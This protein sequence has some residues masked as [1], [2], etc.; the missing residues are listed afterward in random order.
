MARQQLGSFNV[1]SE[2]EDYIITV[3]GEDGTSTEFTANYEQLDLIA[4]AIEEQL[5]M[6]EDELEVEEED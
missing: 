1:R 6:D 4:E 3:E 2:G 5:D